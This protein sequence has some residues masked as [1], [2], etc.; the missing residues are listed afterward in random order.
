MTKELL[1]EKNLE[2]MATGLAATFFSLRDL[3]ARQI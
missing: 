1:A 2:L 3:Y